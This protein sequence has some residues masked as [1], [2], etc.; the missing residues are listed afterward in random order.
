MALIVN[1]IT[2]DF[3]D[4]RAV[5][6]LTIEIKEGRMFGFLGPNGAGKPLLSA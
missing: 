4:V 6:H 1:E 3:R 2:K 5:D